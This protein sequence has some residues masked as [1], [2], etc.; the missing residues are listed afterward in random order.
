MSVAAQFAA[1][2]PFRVRS[3][4]FL[5]PAD[6]AASWA[7]EMEN[8]ILGWYILVETESIHLFTIFVS[9]QFLGTLI[10]PM[11][12]VAADRIGPRSVLCG[13]RAIF[14]VLAATLAALA[15]TDSLTPAWVFA[16]A[17]L[18]GIVR[19]SDQVLRYALV[20]DII[21]A[22][23]LAGALG[24]SRTTMDSARIFGALAGA[25]LAAWLGLGPAYIAITALY[26]ASFV[27]T[28]GVDRVTEFAA[29]RVSAGIP[30]QAATTPLR[31]LFDCFGYVRRT[32]H[33][34]AAMLLALL[35]NITIFP[36]V[37]SLLPYVA[38]EVYGIDRTGLGYL[39]AAFASGAL[40]GSLA[41][42]RIGSN[43]LAGRMTI[44]FAAVWCA[45]ALVFAQ[46]ESF[47]AGLVF[48]ALAGLAQ[49]LSLVPMTVMLIRTS[50]PRYRSRIMGLRMLAVYGL[51][52]GV[53]LSGW[54]IEALGFAGAGALYAGSGLLVTGLIAWHWRKALWPREAPGNA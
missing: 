48:L 38:K 53:L 36:L 45:L 47:T 22:G 54:F 21:P 9:L 50:E 11:V 20:G 35:V 12:G 3:Y 2:A 39:F 43:I 44:A 13:I 19:P 23:G 5:W 8:L 26:V 16:V 15:L 28:R 31:D 14:T 25:G 33:L 32:P 52:V 27:L 17:T 34:L 51:Q 29:P 37:N 24:I 40:L 30:V 42:S 1:L 41:L 4:R 18:M 46:L 7:F 10:A 6:L 49:T